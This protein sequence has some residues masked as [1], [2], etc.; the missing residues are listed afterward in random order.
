MSQYASSLSL[1]PKEKL[2]RIFAT[3]KKCT[4]V[5]PTDADLQ[6]NFYFI[7]P[8]AGPALLARVHTE[9]APSWIS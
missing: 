9:R 4:D 5:D 7:R 1:I 3:I 8:H 2:V 6:I